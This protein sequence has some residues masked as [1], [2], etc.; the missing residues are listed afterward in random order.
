LPLCSDT[1]WGPNKASLRSEPWHQQAGIIHARVDLPS[2]DNSPTVAGVKT[3][4]LLYMFVDGRLFGILTEFP[5]DKFHV[6]C[7]A[8][9]QKYGPVTREIQHP[10]KL[11]WDNP[12]ASV[13]LTRGTVHPV[14]PSILYLEHKQLAKLADSR[15]PSGAADI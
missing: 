14:Q 7:D 13:V 3:D 5:T 2:E 9:I 12:A 10:R 6:V 4:I 8:A 11:M 1:A 15:T